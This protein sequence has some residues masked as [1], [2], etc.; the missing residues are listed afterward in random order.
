MTTTVEALIYSRRGIAD[1]TVEIVFDARAHHL[2][3]IAGQYMTVTVH[4]LEHLD[5]QKQFHDFSI[6]SSPNHPE[7]LTITF[8]I[9]QSSFKQTLLNA[10][11]GTPVTIE[12]P[13]GIFT[14]PHTPERHLVFIAGGIGVTPFMSIISFTTENKLPYIIT[15]FYYNR[16]K[17]SAVYLVELESLAHDNPLFS[18]VPIYGPL[19]ANEI[20]DHIKKQSKE[21]LLFYIAGPPGMVQEARLVLKT[22]MIKD[23]TIKTEEFTGY[24]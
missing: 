14:L 19:D 10:P 5:I 20:Q 3:F 11:L 12:G 13:K 23:D 1:N 16:S 8:R 22:E 2:D 15:L 4:G 24:L 18:F 9:S 6:A 17:E 21:T 7:K